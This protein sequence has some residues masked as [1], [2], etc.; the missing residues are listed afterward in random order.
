MD[1]LGL[2]YLATYLNR[3]HGKNV[4]TRIAK[5]RVDFDDYSQFRHLLETFKPDVIGIRTLTYYSD[6][7]HQTV[8]LIRQWG[9]FIPIITGG[10]YATSDY[11]SILMDQ[12]I[13]I[14]VL[15]EGEITFSQLIRANRDN[16]GQLPGEQQLKDIPGLAFIP[17]EIKKSPFSRNILITDSFFQQKGIE[18]EN[19]LSLTTVKNLLAESTDTNNLSGVT[20]P[21]EQLMGNLAQGHSIYLYNAENPNQ[22]GERMEFRQDTVSTAK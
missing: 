18:S 21:L 4:H 5:S 1:P 2:M 12:N 3:E 10:P 11:R 17:E 14:V 7:F 22:S 6:F 20:T 8:S 16:Q 19:S 9:I 13:D 15:S